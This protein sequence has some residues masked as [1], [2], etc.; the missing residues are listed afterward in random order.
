MREVQA[1]AILDAI[2]TGVS[3]PPPQL[4]GVH[5]GGVELKLQS[6][7]CQPMFEARPT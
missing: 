7:A 6:A 3:L 2:V 5:T 4:E 1:F